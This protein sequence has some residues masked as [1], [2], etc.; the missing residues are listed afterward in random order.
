MSRHVR[1]RENSDQPEHLRKFLH[2]D[3]DD[4]DQTEHPRSI[5]RNYVVY[6]SKQ[7]AK[8][9]RQPKK[10]TVI[11]PCL[12]TEHARWKIDLTENSKSLSF[13][14]NTA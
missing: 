11:W 4:S 7:Y 3:K 1:K 5:V 9:E 12:G 6:S 14:H 10:Q 2:V 8:G 13:S